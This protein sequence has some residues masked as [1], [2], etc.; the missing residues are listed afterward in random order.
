M[1]WGYMQSTI[2]A[3]EIFPDK[4]SNCKS[5]PDLPLQLVTLP[6]TSQINT[7]RKRL[8]SLVRLDVK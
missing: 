7:Q 2:A 4:V 3:E 5:F 1:V 8:G 6:S